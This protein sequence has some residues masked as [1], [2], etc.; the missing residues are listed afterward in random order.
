MK[1]VVFIALVLISFSCQSS[2]PVREFNVTLYESDYNCL[3][4]ENEDGE[5]IITCKGDNQHPEGVVGIR[6]E[7]YLKERNYQKLLINRCKRWED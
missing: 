2:A 5:I 6:F 7:D 4:F 1:A 3:E